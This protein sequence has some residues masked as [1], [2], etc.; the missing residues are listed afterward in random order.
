MKCPICSEELVDNTCPNCGYT[1]KKKEDSS[2]NPKKKQKFKELPLVEK[3]FTICIYI[4]VV[5]MIVWRIM[6]FIRILS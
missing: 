6:R 2:N 3:I 1:D 5:F 4:L